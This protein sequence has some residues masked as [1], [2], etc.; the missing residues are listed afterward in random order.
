MRDGKWKL[1]EFFENGHTELY[2]LEADIEEQHDLAAQHPERVQSMKSSLQV[3]RTDQGA[4]M[5]ERNV[6]WESMKLEVLGQ[7]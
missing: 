7:E 3:W 4:L 2:D 5:P 6:E 1:I